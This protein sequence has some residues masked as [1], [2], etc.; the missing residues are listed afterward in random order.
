VHHIQ[1]QSNADSDGFIGKMHKN[2]VHNLI[3]VCE[4]CHDDIHGGKLQINGVKQTSVGKVLM[5]D[6]LDAFKFKKK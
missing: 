6:R 2:D 5:M 3:A 1:P 4:K